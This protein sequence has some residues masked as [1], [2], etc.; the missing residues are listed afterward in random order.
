MSKNNIDKLM[1]KI[2]RAIKEIWINEIRRD[3]SNSY[4]LYE[5]TLKRF[6]L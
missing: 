6:I 1:L 3:L 4:I 5:D 2:D